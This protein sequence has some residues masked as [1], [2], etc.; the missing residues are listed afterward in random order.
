MKD[1]RPIKPPK[2]PLTIASDAPAT[3]P[4]A[5][6]TKATKA[7]ATPPTPNPL[8]GV[9]IRAEALSYRED[10][11]RPRI[12]IKTPTGTYYKLVPG[13]RTT[14]KAEALQAAQ[15]YRDSILA[16][17]QLPPKGEPRANTPPPTSSGRSRRS[18]T[19]KV[20]GMP[21]VTRVEVD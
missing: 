9:T 5:K 10:L 4:K 19:K 1:R 12:F 17:G 13:V 8:A 2:T 16:S 20:A 15:A 21:G 3:T 18:A 14:T 7:N 6:L 11:H